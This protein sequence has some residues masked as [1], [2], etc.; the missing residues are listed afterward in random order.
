[1]RILLG[2]LQPEHAIELAKHF[3][4][5]GYL[6]DNSLLAALE[7]LD[8]RDAAIDVDRSG[9]KRERFRDARAAPSEREAE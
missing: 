1:V 8:A 2:D 9:R 3:G 7:S 5:Q 4:R 6:P